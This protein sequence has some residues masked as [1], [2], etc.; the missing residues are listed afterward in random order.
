MKFTTKFA[1]V[2]QEL[3]LCE[4]LEEIA[5]AEERLRQDMARMSDIVRTR[6]NPS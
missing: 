2:V 4:R 5:Q 1:Q 6:R 3:G